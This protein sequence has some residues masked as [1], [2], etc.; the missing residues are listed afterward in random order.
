MNPEFTSL[1]KMTKEEAYLIKH[2]HIETCSGNILADKIIAKLYECNS[3]KTGKDQGL[4]LN[5]YEHG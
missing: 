2:K 3:D 4:P 5:M 1:N